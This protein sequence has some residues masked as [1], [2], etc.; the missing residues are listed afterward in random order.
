MSTQWERIRLGFR[1]TNEDY[2][3]LN[4]ILI[5]RDEPMPSYYLFGRTSV[6]QGVEIQLNIELALVNK[7]IRTTK[8]RPY[9][10]DILEF[11]QCVHILSRDLEWCKFR[12]AN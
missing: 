9:S 2:H 5:I 12:D 11:L 7:T 8:L 6:F 4:S 10:M 3:I 1:L